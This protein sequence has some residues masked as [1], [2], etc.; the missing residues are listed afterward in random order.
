MKSSVDGCALGTW[1]RSNCAEVTKAQI[2]LRKK[3]QAMQQGWI[4]KLHIAQKGGVSTERCAN[5]ARKRE[6]C[7]RHYLTHQPVYQ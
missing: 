5:Q 6:L 3:G 4:H 2:V 7:I 1:Q